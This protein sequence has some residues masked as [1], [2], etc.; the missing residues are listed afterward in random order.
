M[1]YETAIK[2]ARSL[3]DFELHQQ[4][5]TKV[6]MA[7]EH[8]A[9]KLELERRE[10][11]HRFWRQDLVAWLALILAIISL[12]VTAVNK[13]GRELPHETVLEKECSAWA[14]NTMLKMRDPDRSRYALL[15]GVCM[16]GGQ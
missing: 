3:S 11:C 1:D 15:L 12:V 5:N 8:I 9:A 13:I 2:K 16:K 7:E 10:R 14:E 6:P 4:V